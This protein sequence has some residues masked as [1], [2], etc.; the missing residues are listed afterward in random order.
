MEF[1]I[2]IILILLLIIYRLYIPKIK[3]IIGEKS[4]SSILFFLDKSKYIVINNVVL[5]KGNN[6]AQ[7][8]HLVISD[9][10]IFVIETKN[11]KGWIV[12]NENSEY[13][14]QIIFKWK[15]KFYNPIK[16]NFGHIIA[17]RECLSLY[18]NIKYISIVVF[19]SKS[20]I[21]VNSLSEV[22]NSQ[23]LIATIKKYNALN[24]TEN[25]KRAIFQKIVN[26]NQVEFYDKKEH[27]K[28]IKKR[29]KLKENSIRENKCP[30]CG[31]KLVL[32]NGKFG[33]FLGCDSFPKCKFI[34][35]V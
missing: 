28:S 11:F 22:I 17:L 29:V 16:Q 15:S 2:S 26:S 32:R 3:G 6:Y 4:I 7:I 30:K 10:G 24:I 8:D 23:K 20:D 19:S 18:P 33:K 27:I 5:K 14:T 25:E 35:N 9:F 31:H 12:G 34:Q 13:W 1:I 21:K